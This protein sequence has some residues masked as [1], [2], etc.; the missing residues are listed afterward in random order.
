[1]SEPQTPG[2]DERDQHARGELPDARFATTLRQPARSWPT[3][4]RVLSSLLCQGRVA[5]WAFLKRSIVS[6]GWVS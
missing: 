4:S 6:G 3:L 2:L 1:M 5:I